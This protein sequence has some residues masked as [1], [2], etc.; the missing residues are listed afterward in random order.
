MKID[1]FKRIDKPGSPLKASFNVL[2]P[3]WDLTLKMTYFEKDNGQS[4]FGYPSREYTNEMGEK[5]H[6]W[7]AFF[8]ERGRPRFEKS[9][10]EELN[11]HLNISTPEQVDWS[12]QDIPF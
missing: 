5:K 10:K 8:G 3:E 2:I 9:L 12:A 11:K 7:L 6:V 1:H 4:W